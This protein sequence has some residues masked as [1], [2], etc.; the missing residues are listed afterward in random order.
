VQPHSGLGGRLHRTYFC[1]LSEQFPQRLEPSLAERPELTNVQRC[2]GTLQPIEQLTS[3][4]RDPSGHDPAVHTVPRSAR[5]PTLF[6]PVEEPG[7][8]G[9]T[10][11]RSLAYDARRCA[12]GPCILKDAQH[13]VLLRRD[14]GR[15]QQ[16]RELMNQLTGEVLEQQVDLPLQRLRRFEPPCAPCRILVL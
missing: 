12:G 15:P 7:Y 9:V 4:P 5:Q 16:R 10:H 3:L 14:T 2:D 6:E 8:V 13:V 11:R 1:R